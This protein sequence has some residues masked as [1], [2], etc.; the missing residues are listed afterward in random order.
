MVF[1]N[2]SELP[3]DTVDSEIQRYFGVDC[4][5]YDKSASF[6]FDRYSHRAGDR[7]DDGARKAAAAAFDP[8]GSQSALTNLL[9]P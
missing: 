1:V 5:R 3:W 7:A 8:I 2:E 4:Y 6:D 9:L